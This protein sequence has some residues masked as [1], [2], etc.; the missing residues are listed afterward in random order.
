MPIVRA[1]FAL[2]GECR[3]PRVPQARCLCAAFCS[4]ARIKNNWGREPARAGARDT[5]RGEPTALGMTMRGQGGDGD[6][7]P[8]GWRGPHQW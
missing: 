3:L 7:L 2:S 1:C 4:G 5:A 8:Q 6:A